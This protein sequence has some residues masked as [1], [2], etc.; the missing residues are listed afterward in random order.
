MTM[1]IDHRLIMM[2]WS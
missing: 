2:K 1:I